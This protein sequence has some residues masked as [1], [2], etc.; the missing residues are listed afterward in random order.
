VIR[1]GHVTPPVVVDLP[2]PILGR[3]CPACGPFARG[4]VG[5]V[6]KVLRADDETMVRAGVKAIPA[7]V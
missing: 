5:A 4:A 3:I 1:L 2:A 6:T 7:D